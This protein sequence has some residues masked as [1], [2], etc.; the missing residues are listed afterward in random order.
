MRYEINV[1]KNGRHFFATAQRS[2]TAKEEEA[3]KVFMALKER[4]YEDDGYKLALTYW[5]TRGT[6]ISEEDLFKA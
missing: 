5:E 1:S 6:H 2:I 4:F 3:Q